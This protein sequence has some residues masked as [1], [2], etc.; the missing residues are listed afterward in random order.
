MRV[1]CFCLL[2][3]FLTGSSEETIKAD[4]LL[5][6]ESVEH[7]DFDLDWLAV[8]GSGIEREV[9]FLLV[10]AEVD[11]LPGHRERDE[12]VAEPEKVTTL[13]INAGFVDAVRH[14]VEI[15]ST[16]CREDD[17]VICGCRLDFFR[18]LKKKVC[19]FLFFFA[20][21]TNRQGRRGY[22]K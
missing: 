13:V 11:D 20:V 14:S 12:L 8:P 19:V 1:C 5:R 6:N 18:F 21:R 16:I 22:Q 9:P 17:T 2:L 3:G 10:V 4:D 7:S 15:D